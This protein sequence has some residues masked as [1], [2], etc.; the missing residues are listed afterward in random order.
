[1]KLLYKKE[2]NQSNANKLYETLD[3]CKYYVTE[4]FPTQLNLSNQT[5]DSL[6][7]LNEYIK[8][9]GIISTFTENSSNNSSDKLEKA[10]YIKSHKI[11][12]DTL[13]ILKNVNNF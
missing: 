2:T 3:I 7:K 10:I 9:Y 8:T 11:S 6:T 13:K 12:E 5:P 1:M 4:K